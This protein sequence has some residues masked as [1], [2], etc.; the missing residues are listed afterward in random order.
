MEFV[1]LVVWDLDGV[2]WHGALA[3]EGITPRPEMQ[4]IVRLLALRGI[5]SS[6]CSRNDFAAARAK[7][8]ELGMW[9]YFVFPSISWE[10]KG[11]R[12]A[13]LVRAAQLRPGSVL[14]IDD[15]PANLEEAR[16]ALPGLQVMGPEQVPYLL[17]N[18]WL[19]GA[20]DPQM[21]RL[22]HYRLLA[23]RQE[24]AL[25]S[26]AD[27]LAFLRA[28]EIRV[29]VDYD[30]EAHLDRAVELVN[31]TNQ[32]NFTKWRLPEDPEAARAELRAWVRRHDVLTGV[33]RV[34]DRYGDHGIAGFFSH[35]E[36]WEL[37]HFCFSCRVMG[38]GVEQFVYRL[39][40]RPPLQLAPPVAASLDY[41]EVDWITQAKP[42]G[43]PQLA[44]VLDRLV[45]RGGC[46]L[47]AMAHYLAPLTRELCSEYN[48][49]RGGRQF[50]IDHAL[51]LPLA[52]HPPGAET[53]A[54]LEGVGYTPADWTSA[55]ARP[56]PEGGRE[57]WLFSFWTDAFI[58]LY[59]HNTLG[60]AVP[61][62]TEDEVR[63]ET[64]VTALPED[65]PMSPQNRAALAAL[66]RDFTCIGTLDEPSLRAAVAAV[67]AAARGRAMCVFMALPES[68]RFAPGGALSPMPR[69][70]RLNRWLR[71]A[72]AGQPGAH[73]LD[74]AELLPPDW[75]APERFHY[76]RRA[77][78]LAA[79]RIA[80]LV[81]ARFGN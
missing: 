66:R 22:S 5:V 40:G 77:Y 27:N 70:A 18:P 41:P 57:V 64:D 1:R 39:L 19:F 33:V 49:A 26:G 10:P 72:L 6:I 65:L 54:A 29:V 78:R 47:S 15:L 51:F 7:L 56:A 24:A 45:L 80:A 44:P 52:L 53:A 76:E 55:L 20:P 69:E 67:L 3:E 58:Q 30:V 79:E 35:L 28:S 75:S 63:A 17:E 4:E 31:R 37:K 13:A 12:I 9:A 62:L 25:A 61:F 23:E 71:E 32:L 2:F 42:D 14:F 16:Q 50:R 34:S 68:W 43:T 21:Q 73:V 38:M 74:M 8:Q 48:L 59:R 46:D 81:A 11:Q 36:G 60:I